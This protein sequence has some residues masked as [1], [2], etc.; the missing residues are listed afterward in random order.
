MLSLVDTNYWLGNLKAN[1]Y[2]ANRFGNFKEGNKFSAL[3]A[4][5]DLSGVEWVEHPNSPG[6]FYPDLR[7][8]EYYTCSMP[9]KLALELGKE[10]YF[11]QQYAASFYLFHRQHK[12]L[13]W[14][15]KY[16]ETLLDFGKQKERI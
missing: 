15:A 10:F 12:S 7:G 2:K 4:Y 6:I 8:A 13:V 11:L 16:I 1:A 9:D 3:G 5:L 14:Q